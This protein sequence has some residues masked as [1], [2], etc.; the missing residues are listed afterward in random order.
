MKETYE[1][2]ICENWRKAKIEINY[3]VGA[4]AGKYQ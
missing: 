2:G 1:S 4:E 3:L